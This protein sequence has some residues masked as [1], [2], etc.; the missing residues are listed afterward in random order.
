MEESWIL[1]VAK[2]VGVNKSRRSGIFCL[3]SNHCTVWN[4]EGG[5]KEG[6]KE[7]RWEGGTCIQ[8]EIKRRQGEEQGTSKE[9]KDRSK[10][11]NRRKEKEKHSEGLVCH[12]QWRIRVTAS[13]TTLEFRPLRLFPCL[14]FP[15]SPP[16]PPHIKTRNDV[17][18]RQFRQLK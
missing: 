17:Q 5:R 15:A 9:R 14:S 2:E 4:L 16:P 6:R 12:L 11:D 18:L 1:C 13:A 7:G 3:A 10:G 8:K